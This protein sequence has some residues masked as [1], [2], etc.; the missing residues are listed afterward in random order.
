DVM[1]NVTIHTIFWA[2]PGYH[3]DGSPTRGTLGYEALVKQFLVDVAHDSAGPHNLFSTLTQ[4]QD[5]HGLGS[6]RVSYDPAVDSIDLSAPYPKPVDQCASLAGIG[7]CVTDLELEQQINRLIGPH[8]PGARGLSN[9]WF[10]LL[11]PDVDTCVAQGACATTA[12]AG[13]HSVFELGQGPTIYSSIPDP[14]VEFTPPPGSD[15]QGNPEA[16][17][18]L[19]TIGHETEEAITDPYGNA[20]MDPNGFEVADKCENPEDGVPLGFAPNG[21]PYNQ[22]INGHQYLIQDMWSNAVTGCVQS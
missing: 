19:D 4:Y 18:T 7:T 8:D 20:W 21:S 3:F 12:F 17:Q 10:I 1:R 6:T 2:P 13:Y 14:L 9:I 5:G 22:V 11:P 15:P 16:E